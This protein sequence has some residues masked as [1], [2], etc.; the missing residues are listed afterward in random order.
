MANI[1]QGVCKSNDPPT[2]L[3][4]RRCWNLVM[5]YYF[6]KKPAIKHSCFN[7]VPL[8]ATGLLNLFSVFAEN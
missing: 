4:E 5:K 3:P 7:V 1:L 2:E 8:I 6:M